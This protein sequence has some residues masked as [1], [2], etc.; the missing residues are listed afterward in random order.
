[1]IGQV[2]VTVETSPLGL[3]RYIFSWIANS[4]GQARIVLNGRAAPQ[5]DGI[6]VR[7]VTSPSPV[8]PPMAG[9]DVKLLTDSDYD[10]FSGA[11]EGLSARDVET[12]GIRVV[13]AGGDR[14][15]RLQ[16]HRRITFSVVNA[17]DGGAGLACLYVMLN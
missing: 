6:P 8:S 9:Y 4:S 5:F 16:N 7:L 14:F 13:L 1:M 3:K 15:A 2:N 12:V 17:G 11:G 10:L